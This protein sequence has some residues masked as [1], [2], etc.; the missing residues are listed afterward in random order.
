[1]DLTY[2]GKPII[3]TKQAL[4]ELSEI[5]LNLSDVPKILEKGFELRKRK[6]NVIEKGIQKGD[7]VINVVVV[8]L[9]GYYKL[10]HAGEFT[11]TH[12]FR[13]LIRR[14]DGI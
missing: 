12:K 2:N 1:M 7:K 3:P 6:K 9:G 14:Q 10:I 5:N 4:T 8:D 13:K 11:L